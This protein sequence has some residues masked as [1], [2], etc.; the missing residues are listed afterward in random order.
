MRR[1]NF[2]DYLF[3]CSSIGK[4]MTNSRSKSDPLSQTAKT[5]LKDL[6]K[7]EIFNRRNEIQSKYLDKGIQVE[8]KSISLYSEVMDEL[9]IKNKERFNNDFITGEPDNKQNLVRDIKSSW[10]FA[11]FPIYETEI[12]NKIYY[13]QLMGYMALT[14]LK[15]AELVYCLVDTPELL[16][17]DEKRRMSWKLGMLELPESL[18]KE[19]E[20]NM[21]YSDIPKELRIK[22]FELDYDEEAV[23]KLYERIKICREFLNKLSE[24]LAKNIEVLN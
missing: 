14:G 13:W 9:F 5:Y 19:L 8:E 18:E 20:E 16:I 17:E 10:N 12:P 6:H 23:T 21:T 11:T 22:V 1:L 7:E 3:R 24:E 4:L 15:S 2:D